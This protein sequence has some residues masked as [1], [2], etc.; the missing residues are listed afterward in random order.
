MNPF[1]LAIDQGTTGSR[2]FLFNRKAEVVASAYQEFPQYYPRPGWVEHDAEEIWQS[3]VAVIRRAVKEAGI[4][5]KDISAV[6]ITNQ[7][8]TTVLWDRRTSRPVSRAVV[9]QCRRTAALCES[10]KLRALA[11]VIRRKT[12][13]VLDPYFSGTKIK[14]LLDNVKGARRRALKG[15]LCFGTID[16][17]LIWKLTGGRSH[18]TDLTNASR[19]MIFN[20]RNHQWDP[21]L[22]KALDIPSEILPSA[23]KSGAVFGKTAPDIAG[24]SAGTPIAAVMGDQQA[25][26]YGQGCH[27]PGTV[28]NTYGTGCFL[29]L[30]TGEKLIHSRKGLIS[31]V[32]CDGTGNPVYALE[33]SIFIAGAV[34]QW[35][36]DELKV[37]K[38]SAESEV[39]AKG[40]ADTHGVYVVPAF[41][42]LGAPYLDSSAR[43]LITGLTRGA[44]V[45]HLVRAA[46]E[47]IAYQTKD[48]FDLMQQEFDRTI[49]ELNVDGGACRNDFLMQFQADMLQCRIL[50]PKIIETTARGAALL[51]GVTVGLW[52]KN[53]LQSMRHP[54]KTFVPRMNPHDAKDLYSGWLKAVRK[55]RN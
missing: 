2:A 49:P 5:P 22:L 53:D 23:Q 9:W 41:T 33:G 34:V 18:M 26:L 19:T 55:V 31:T 10:K 38:D 14:W 6:G 29:V 1:I 54:E 51:A 8:E 30:N 4:A 28:K 48:V 15:E 17:W 44:N 40:V 45:Q 50:R 24:L 42:G 27:H 47:S 3:C 36:R 46:L 16:S 13:L 35:L 21:E 20:I 7:R 43:G 37:L 39:M 52:D 12:G 25:A 11:P 32:A